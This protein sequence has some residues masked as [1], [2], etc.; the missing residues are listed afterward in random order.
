[1]SAAAK[2]AVVTGAYCT[3]NLSFAYGSAVCC[4]PFLKEFRF[5]FPS[6]QD[7]T[8]CS[9]KLMKVPTVVLGWSSANN[10]HK[11]APTIPFTPFVAKL[12]MI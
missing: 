2:N 6:S 1:M 11:V 5:S 7:S 4:L 8:D 10:F 3:L 9:L 12:A